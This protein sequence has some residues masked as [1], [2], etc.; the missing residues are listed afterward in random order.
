MTARVSQRYGCEKS[1]SRGEGLLL[2]IV[3]QQNRQQIS[4]S[5]RKSAESVRTIR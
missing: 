1:L 2:F 3:G 5:D 4:K